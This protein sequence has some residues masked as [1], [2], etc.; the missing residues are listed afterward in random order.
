MVGLVRLG[1]GSIVGI[2]ELL[3]KLKIL[4]LQQCPDVEDHE[5]LNIFEKRPDLLILNYYGEQ[6]EKSKQFWACYRAHKDRFQT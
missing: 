6:V 2:S 4:D 3:P 1:S 5:L